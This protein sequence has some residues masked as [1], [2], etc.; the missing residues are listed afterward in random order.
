M[1]AL[2]TVLLYLLTPLVLARLLWRSR[3]NPGYRARW[4][5]RFALYVPLPSRPRI[6]VHAVSVGEVIAAAPLLRRLLEQH[7]DHALLVTTTTPTGSAQVQRLFGGN[8]EHVYLP[9]DLPGT[10]RRFLAKARPRVAVFMET[11]LWPNLFAACGAR[12]VPIVVAN[13]RLSERSARGYARFAGFTRATLEK[14]SLVAARGE[15]DAV[16]F[17]ALGAPRVEVVGNIKYDLD[18]P[19]STV[20]AGGAVRKAL[21]RD[22]CVWI[23]ASTHAGE[24]ELVL[25]AHALL[26]AQFPEAALILV[27]RHPERFQAVAELCGR[28]GYRVARRSRGELVSREVDVLLGDTM[29][30]LLPLYAAADLAFVGGSLVPTGGHNP[31][32]PAALGLPVLSGP[33]TF[34]FAEVFPLLYGVDAALEVRDP[35]ELAETAARL[36]ADALERTRR[37]EA[38]RAVVEA[39]R[40][41]VG[42]LASVV[43]WM[44]RESGEASVALAPACKEEHLR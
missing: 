21:G 43:E 23:A 39:N 17:R 10:V 26:R 15:E 29:G 34:N 22:R 18:V 30:E 8:V 6:W 7:S 14:V 38:G 40:G 19:A 1:R 2:Y 33:H 25:E 9:Y 41:T 11:E 5:E 27:P 36:L 20:E 4:G 31:L 35:R 28:A 24:D 42:R 32:E 3:R 12:G 16:R 44:L 13:A 37:G